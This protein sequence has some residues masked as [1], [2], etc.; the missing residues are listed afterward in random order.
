MGEPMTDRRNL[1][2]GALGVVACPSATGAAVKPEIIG[3]G[4]QFPEGPVAFPDGSLVFVEVARGTLTRLWGG[5]RSE[6]VANLGGGPNGASL[7]PDGAIYVC[8]NGGLKPVPQPDGR[9]LLTAELSSDYSGGRIERVDLASRKVERLYSEAGRQGL[10]GPN[11]LVFDRTGGFWFS[12]FGKAEG[13]RRDFSALY[14]AR[15]DGSRIAV[16]VPNGLSFNGIGLSPDETTV[17]VADTYSARLWAYDLESPGMIRK[18]SDGSP[19]RRLAA[20][21]PGDIHIDGLSMTASGAA[22][23]AT[24]GRGLTSVK[25][26]GSMQLTPLSETLVNDLCFGGSDRRDVYVTLPR[27]GAIGRLRWPEP[28]RA[29]NFNPY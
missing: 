25:P 9:I 28:G 23:V 26:D 13:L 7:G 4:F 24:I 19:A 8:N 18:A 21:I 29:L 16:A 12:D 27:L 6:V 5:G 10:R 17:Y 3:E 2:A 15:A 11:D 20:T 1:L 14:Y 22:V